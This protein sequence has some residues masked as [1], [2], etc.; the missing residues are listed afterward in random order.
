MLFFVLL[1]H[2]VHW[3]ASQDT[4]LLKQDHDEG[5]C[6]PVAGITQCVTARENIVAVLK[7][8][9]NARAARPQTSQPEFMAVRDVLGKKKRA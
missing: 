6:P 1:L 3:L 8:R 9:A 5:F 2:P 7:R 4:G